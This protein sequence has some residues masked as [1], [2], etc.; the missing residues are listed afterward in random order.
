[1]ADF[2][3][4]DAFEAGDAEDVGGE[5]AGVEVGAAGVHVLVAFVFEVGLD[6]FGVVGDADGVFVEFDV[7][8]FAKDEDHLVLRGEAVA[9]FVI[10]DRTIPDDEVVELVLAGEVGHEMEEGV[11]ALSQLAEDEGEAVGA[12]D[13]HG[14]SDPRPA[15]GEVGV[16]S[17]PLGIPGFIFEDVEVGGVGDDGLGGG[18]GEFLEFLEGVAF[19]DAVGFHPG[20]GALWRVRLRIRWNR[21]VFPFCVWGPR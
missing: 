13:T 15:P 12:E 7:V 2:F 10:T 16:G 1:M 21:W 11:L 9:T 3:F 8:A 20:V 5:L 4:G 18:V 19:D 17:W 6:G 14:F